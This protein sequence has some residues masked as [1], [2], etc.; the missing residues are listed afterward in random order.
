[1]AAIRVAFPLLLLAS[2]YSPGITDGQ[3]QCKN[4]LCPSGFVCICGGVCKLPGSACTDG[5]GAQ[6]MAGD[7]SMVISGDM[8]RKN[9]DGCSNG[10][11]RAMSD[12]DLPNVAACPAAFQAPGI[13]TNTTPCNRA[14][15]MTGKVGGT[16]CSAEDNCAA[17][18]HVCLNETELMM[19]GFGNVQCAQLSTAATFWVTRQ[20]GGPTMPP[21]GP[22]ACGNPARTMFGCGT[23]GEAPG[24]CTILNRVLFDKPTAGDDCSTMSGGSWQCPGVDDMNP[25]TKVVRKPGIAGG[26]VLCCRD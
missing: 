17:G 5:G 15:N 7:M 25:D 1:M 2:C 24:A 4:G 10:G 12:P 21:T 18:W 9:F 11:T 14:P 22:P 20:T 3:F 13:E 6:D 26:G 19:R 16:D 23:Y 8:I